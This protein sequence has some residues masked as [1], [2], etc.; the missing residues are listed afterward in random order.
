MSELILRPFDVEPGTPEAVGDALAA[1]VDDRG[2]IV[3]QA[4]LVGEPVPVERRVVE[5]VAGSPEVLDE[6]STSTGIVR[7]VRAGD[8]SL[9]D[10]GIE[11]G[12]DGEL[13]RPPTDPDAAAALVAERAGVPVALVSRATPTGDPVVLGRHG[14]VPVG[15]AG[16]LM[17]GA[18]AV[19]VV[20]AVPAPAPQ[21]PAWPGEVTATRALGRRAGTPESLEIG[22]RSW[23]AAEDP[24]VRVGR[25]CRL[26]VLPLPE[27][28]SW[29]PIRRHVRTQ[30]TLETVR[31]SVLQLGVRVE[32]P[33]D[34]TLGI[35]VGRLIV[36][37]AAEG[38]TGTPI[39]VDA[40]PTSVLVAVLAE[41]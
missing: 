12:P 10:A 7:L 35:A 39:E 36:A 8:V 13:R 33:D 21:R 14:E 18:W 30:I 28:P 4:L 34:L 3:L 32:A 15:V 16:L 38:L 31:M 5:A 19:H 25:A 24:E 1:Q 9:V 6:V 29:H 11:A 40:S 27:I 20:G 23:D 26:A 37:L 17:P 2:L 41:S 22:L